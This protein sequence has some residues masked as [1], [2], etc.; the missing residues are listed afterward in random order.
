MSWKFSKKVVT[1]QTANLAKNEYRFAIL[2]TS[3]GYLD[4]N[5]S[6]LSLFTVKFEKSCYN[7]A[8]FDLQI[9]GHKL[10]VFK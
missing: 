4:G 8:M 3:K 1:E 9:N 6:M 7:C 2:D 5:T 10:G